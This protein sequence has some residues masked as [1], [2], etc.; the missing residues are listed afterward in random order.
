[1]SRTVLL[2]T[3]A[4]HDYEGLPSDVRRRL[5]SALLT[6][7]TTGRGNLKKLKGVGKGTDLYRLRVGDFR[8]VFAMNLKEIQVTRIIP[9][10]EG[11]DWL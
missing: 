3:P 8:V 4:Q 11:Y 6:F 9:R 1:M 10:S 2:S 5:R 7:A